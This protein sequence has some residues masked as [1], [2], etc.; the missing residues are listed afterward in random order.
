MFGLT[1]REQ[2]W[3][4]EQK[5]A[6]TIAGVLVAAVNAK[7]HRG[8]E[9]NKSEQLIT[10]LEGEIAKRD[11][12]LAACRVAVENCEV[13]RAEL[14]TIKEQDPIGWYTEDHLDDKSATTYSWTVA[15]RWVEKGWPVSPLYAAPVSEAKAQGVVIPDVN[16]AAKALCNRHAIICGVDADDQWKEYSQDFIADA[17]TVLA[18]ARL[19]AAPVQQ[20]K[21]K[22]CNDNGRIGGP[23][24][25]A[26]DEGGE[27]CPDCSAPVQ[28]VSVPDGWRELAKRADDFL[29]SLPETDGV[30]RLR[31]DL[32]SMLAAPAAPA[33]DAGLVDAFCKVEQAL[34]LIGGIRHGENVTQDELWQSCELLDAA[35]AANR[36]K[37]AAKC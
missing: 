37:G 9:M 33:A 31:A 15:E 23:S 2:R 1:K 6:E 35:L 14:A 32:C 10:Y 19:N 22:T 36:A 26:P 29:Y 20:P 28:Q 3:K 16:A 12:E 4:A 24:F 17:E 34:D 18:N 11:E 21:C 7:S 8:E 13:F 30:L 25:Y 27:P 5:A